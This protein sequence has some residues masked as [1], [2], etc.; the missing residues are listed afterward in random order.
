[1]VTLKTRKEIK[2]MRAANLMV[3]EV[4]EI[5]A[6]MVSP[7]IT[8]MDLEVRAAEEAKKRGV[9]PAFKGY[10]GFPWCLC[11]SP[12][13]VVVHGMP[14]KDTV[15]EEGDIL[16]MDF[17]VRYRGYF[18]DS[19]ITVPVGEISGKARRLLDI[20]ALSLEK[21]IEAA[22]PGNY[23]GDI[24]SA[25]QTCVE[26]EG[27]SVVRDFVGHGIGKKLH[28]PPQVPN[29]GRP[30]TGIRLLPGMVLAI[31]PMINEGGYK[32]RV[33]DDGWT[34]V[35]ADGSLSAHF[36]HTVAITEDGPYVLSRP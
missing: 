6:D 1:M 17:G 25:V 33:L 19:A 29:F 34:A 21:A 10:Y 36:E 16:G 12:N 20:T 32:T 27:F 5:L 2:I 35:T 22:R 26:A 8:T 11:A 30:G 7:G 4:L 31:E 13:N 15:L 9:K 23:L 28:E 3:A 24:S 18:G 14:S